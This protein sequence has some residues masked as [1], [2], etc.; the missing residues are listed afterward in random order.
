MTYI[1]VFVNRRVTLRLG[2]TTKSVDQ[3]S[4]WER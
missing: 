3:Q 2:W 4:R 1:S